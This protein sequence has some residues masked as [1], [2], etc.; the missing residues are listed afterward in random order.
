MRF[1]Y[2]VR[3]RN[4][5]FRIG[6]KSSGRVQ[7]IRHDTEISIAYILICLN[8]GYNIQH[9]YSYSVWLFRFYF[10]LLCF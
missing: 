1:R 7:R 3:W 2:S 10:T 8:F 4:P 9:K 6:I 5:S